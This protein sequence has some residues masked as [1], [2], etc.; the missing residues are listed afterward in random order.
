M[1]WG[2]DLRRHGRDTHRRPLVLHPF[3]VAAGILGSDVAEHLD[4]GHDDV[5]LFAHLFADA[6]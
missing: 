2:D 1:D 6:A 5:E 3:T 4:T